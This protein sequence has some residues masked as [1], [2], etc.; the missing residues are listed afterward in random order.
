MTRRA[1]VSGGG[2]PEEVAE[3]AASLASEQAGFATGQILQVHGG[4]LLGRG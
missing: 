2:T 4:W 3:A 1:V